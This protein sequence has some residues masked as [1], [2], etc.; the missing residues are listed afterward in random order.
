[1]KV[2]ESQI[3]LFSDV[4]VISTVQGPAGLPGLR[5]MKGYPGMDGPP[6]L[7]G[8][9]GFPGKPGRKVNKQTLIKTGSHIIIGF[10]LKSQ[11]VLGTNV[12][13]VLPTLDRWVLT[14]GLA[15]T[16]RNNIGIFSD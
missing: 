14:F 16:L 2:R 8:L 5:G 11:H 15:S 10:F 1:M 13:T 7:T 6:G 12:L 4:A 9:P 3:G